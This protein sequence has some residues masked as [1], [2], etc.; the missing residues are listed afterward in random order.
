MQL[1]RKRCKIFTNSLSSIYTVT[2]GTKIVD[3][4]NFERLGLQQTKNVFPKPLS[5]Y[6]SRKWAVNSFRHLMS[7]TGTF[8]AK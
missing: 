4:N 8:A 3:L 1:Y 5:A 6:L 7:G 2:T